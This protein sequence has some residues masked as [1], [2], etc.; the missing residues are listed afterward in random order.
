M[1]IRDSHHAVGSGEP[2]GTAARQ[3]H[4]MD[5]VDEVAGVEGVGL[6]GPWSA[7]AYVDRGDGTTWCQDHRRPGLPAAADAVVVTD[8]KPVDIDERASAEWIVGRT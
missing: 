5:A 7:A 6:A 2:V 1:C 3:A 8:S 4:G